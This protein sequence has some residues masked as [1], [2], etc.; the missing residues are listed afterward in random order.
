MRSSRFPV[1]L[2]FFLAQAF[3]PVALAGVLPKID[4]P[5]DSPVAVVS[6][7]FGD[8]N[9]MARGGAMLLDLHAALSLR[10]S[11]QRR[12]RGITLLVMAQDATP[13]GKGS[14]TVTSL[15]VGP[16]E[17]FPLR[18]DLRLLRPLQ[19][20]RGAPV[21]IGLDGVLFDDLG[22]YGPD[23][24]SSRRALT[25][26]EF[27]ARRDRKYFKSLLSE[28]GA[29]R[30]QQAILASLARQADR[31]AFDVQVV[32]GGRATNFEPEKQVQF[33]FL[34]LPDSPVEPTE[35]MARIFGNEA[36]APR[37]EVKNRSSRPIRYL[38]IGWI[39]QDRNGRQFLA[40]SVPAELQLAPGQKS[41]IL[42]NSTLKF[43]QRGG[44]PLAIEGMTGFV[45][46][47][48]YSDGSVWIPSR[49]DLDSPELQRVAA[50]SDEEQRLV[51][52]YRKRGLN[53]LVTELN[54]F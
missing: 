14:V 7:D 35:G 11:S 39:L 29:P 19:A 13:G 50:P 17:S 49:A 21:E 45:S 4:L 33:A 48:E 46:S 38:E 15:D 27:E 2:A 3:R 31:P 37:L 53:A 40:G 36:R 20:S 8:S 44:P 47:V 54:R 16:G 41:Q 18:I 52:I 23:K 25:V 22:F 24:L 9:E 5:A 10:N 34:K 30:L 26:S 43:P 6:A 42:E 1:A 51:Q 32:R 28:G 12:I